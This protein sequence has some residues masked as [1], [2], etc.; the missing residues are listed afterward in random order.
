MLPEF[1]DLHA[2]AALYRATSYTILSSN[3][4]LQAENRALLGDLPA[5]HRDTLQALIRLA[6]AMP[7]TWSSP[8]YLAH[9]ALSCLNVLEKCSPLS[10][11]PF[12]T[13]VPLVLTAPSL[14]CKQAGPA[15]P[16]H[17]ARQITLQCLRALVTRLMITMDVTDCVSE[18]MDDDDTKSKVDLKSLLPMLSSVR[19]GFDTTGKF[20]DIILNNLISLSL[21]QDYAFNVSHF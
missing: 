17:L 14:F 13:L 4:V 15:R 9:H 21:F 10:H 1:G 12:G 6:A 18:P 16:T 5:R 3:A 19:R 7:S 20:N 11:E 8:K 2:S